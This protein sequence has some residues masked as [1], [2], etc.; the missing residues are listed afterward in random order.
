MADGEVAT[1]QL[2]VDPHKR[3]ETFTSGG[4]TSISIRGSSDGMR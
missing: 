2:A 1:E 4:S 3:V